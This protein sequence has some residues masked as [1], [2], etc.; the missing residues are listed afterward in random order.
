MFKDDFGLSPA[1]MGLYLSYTTTPWIVK[2]FWG[3]ITDSKPLF[4]Y[5]RKSYIIVFGVLDALG[6]VS[7]AYYGINS[8]PMALLLLFQIQ[9]STCFVNVV[10]EAILVEVAAA[11]SRNA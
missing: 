11:S 10:G 8:L 9:L 5:R 4:G 2:P 7:L 6:W 1:M 3:I